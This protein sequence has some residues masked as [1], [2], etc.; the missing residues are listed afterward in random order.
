MKLI[1]LDWE[2]T[3]VDFQ[4]DL[5]GA[6]AET[7]ALLQ[8]KAV[9]QSFSGMDYAAIYNLVQEKGAQW[10]FADGSLL[11]L[12]DAVYDRYDL[13]AASRWITCEGLAQTLEALKGYRLAL[14]T[15]IGRKGIGRMLLNNAALSG[16]FGLILTRD[17]LPYLKPHP[18]GLQ[19]AMA[20]AGV[21]P[22]ETLHIGDSLSDLFA[23]R[24]AGVKIGV[25]LGG[26]NTTETLLRE[27]P[28]LVLEKLSHLPAAIQDIRSKI[29]EAREESF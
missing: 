22:H 3:L 24:N 7:T 13:D 6:V 27:S 11:T 2:G 16:S 5:A 20:W 1:T 26:Q 21:L 17:D 19:K 18:G 12:I 28:D 23:A 29:Q 10:G 4:W 14:V 25:V 9:P 15:N 8:V